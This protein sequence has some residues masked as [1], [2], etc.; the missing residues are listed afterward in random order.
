MEPAVFERIICLETG[1]GMIEYGVAGAPDAPALL[2]LHAIR[3]TKMLFAGIVPAL[4]QKYR[5]IAVDL[6]GHGHTTA[7]GPY[8]F[9]QI[10]TDIMHV[11][12]AE[13]LEQV[14]I[15]AASFAAVPAQMLAVREPQRVSKL[16]LLDG[17]FYSLG[18]VPGF[19]LEAAVERLTVVRF[20]ST[21]DAEQQF[22]ERYTAACMPAGWMRGELEPKEA[23]SYGYR[24]AKEAFSGYFQE[25][26]TQCTT[27]LYQRLECPVLLL[28]ADTRL[29]PDEEYRIF[30]R[31]AARSYQEAVRD[32]QVK[33]IPDSL[34]LL[35]VTHPQETVNEIMRFLQK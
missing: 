10:T 2:L 23:G 20:L 26:V 3:N 15:V 19:D 12:D 11:L 8:T 22:A 21:R 7:A 4:A 33:T 17:G 28:L 30:Y 18:E 16:V 25:Y 35:M 6:R 29:Q 34:H 32:V 31:E 9:E 1:A 13:Q 27:A 5:V 24:L 14:V